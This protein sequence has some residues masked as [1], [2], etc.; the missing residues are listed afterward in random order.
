MSLR[1]YRIIVT[2][3][4]I[5]MCIFGRHGLSF[6]WDGMTSDDRYFFNNIGTHSHIRQLLRHE[7]KNPNNKGTRLITILLL[8]RQK[9]KT[10]SWNVCDLPIFLFGNKINLFCNKEC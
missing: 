9:K 2:Y 1:F 3:S 5:G 10:F 6:D 4:I 7:F 8:L